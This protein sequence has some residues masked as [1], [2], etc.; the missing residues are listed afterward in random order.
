MRVC[1]AVLC[2]DAWLDRTRNT[3][4]LVPRRRSQHHTKPPVKC[5]AVIVSLETSTQN[6]A[7][8]EEHRAGKEGGESGQQVSLS[9]GA[10][11]HATGEERRCELPDQRRTSS[12]S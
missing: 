10:P 4:H 12:I 3:L 9:H 7:A 1:C 6:R 8:S 5:T 2:R 11:H